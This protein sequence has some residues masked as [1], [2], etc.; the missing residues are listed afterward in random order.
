MIK[1]YENGKFR[2]YY[3]DNVPELWVRTVAMHNHLNW[4]FFKIEN[5]KKKK[6]TKLSLNECEEL[7]TLKN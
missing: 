6:L 5:G 2:G 4:D 3:S 7:S 1:A